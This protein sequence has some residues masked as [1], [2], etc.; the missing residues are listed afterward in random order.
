MRRRLSLP[1]VALLCCVAA[2]GDAPAAAM[3]GASWNRS[4]QGLSNANVEAQA[5]C[6]LEREQA[7]EAAGKLEDA[8]SALEDKERVMR[9][10]VARN[11]ALES[12][13]FA[14]EMKQEE[15]AR[16]LH[17]VT[18]AN[19]TDI[20]AG[21]GDSLRHMGFDFATRLATDALHAERDSAKLM[22][23]TERLL[24]VARSATAAAEKAEKETARAQMST[25]KP[26]IESAEKAAW[27]TWKEANVS[28]A[29]SS[30]EREEIF[31]KPVMKKLAAEVREMFVE[32]FDS[33]MTH[34]Y[35]FDEL[36]P[37][38][39]SGRNVFGADGYALTL[40]DSLDTLAMMGEWERFD[41]A[42]RR[43]AREV[44]FD[45]DVNVSVFETNIR[46]LGG[47]LSAH[48]MA[49]KFLPWYTDELLKMSVDLADRMM[50]AFNTKT[51]IPYGTVNLRHGV[52][53]G[54][55]TVTS[56]AGGGTNVVEFVMLSRIT[57][58]PKY[59][60]AAR[61]ATVGLWS[62][63]SKLGLVGNHINIETG[64]W[65]HQD[66]GLGTN[67]DSFYEY[68][69]KGH[70]LFGDSDF[71]AMFI[72][73]YQGIMK[74]IR[75]GVW[76]LDVNMHSGAVSWMVYSSLASFWPG[77]QV[78]VGDIEPA[79][80]TQYAIHS[81]W[82]RFGGIPEAFNLESG[83]LHNGAEGYPLRPESIESIYYLHKATK[84]PVWVSMGVDALVS[85]QTL[86]KAQCGYA[87]TANVATRRLD[88][89]MDSYFLA[90]TLKYLYLLFD[91]D[92]WLRGEEYV[93]NTEGHPLPVKSEFLQMPHPENGPGS[94]CGMPGKPECTS[95]P[96]IRG[97][98]Q[99]PAFKRMI[100]AYGF[101]LTLEEEEEQV[102]D[103]EED[104]EVIA[105][106]KSQNAVSDGSVKDATESSLS[107]TTSPHDQESLCPKRFYCPE[108]E[109]IINMYSSEEH[110]IDKSGRKTV[111]LPC[112]SGSTSELGS[113]KKSD[114]KCSI[115]FSGPDGG[116][117]NLD[118]VEDSEMNKYLD[119]TLQ[120]YFEGSA[121]PQTPEV[122]ARARAKIAQYVRMSQQQAEARTAAPPD[123]VS[124]SDS[125][126][127]PDRGSPA[128]PREAFNSCTS[129]KAPSYDSTRVVGKQTDMDEKRAAQQWLQDE[130]DE[131]DNELP[132]PGE[133]GSPVTRQDGT[134]VNSDANG[135]SESICERGQGVFVPAP[136][137]QKNVQ[138]QG[139]LMLREGPCGWGW[140]VGDAGAHLSVVAGGQKG[141]LREQCEIMDRQGLYHPDVGG[142][143][144]EGT[145]E[146]GQDHPLRVRSGPCGIGWYMVSDTK[147][148]E[149]A[150]EK[151]DQTRILEGRSRESMRHTLKQFFP[152]TF[153]PIPM[154]EPG[155]RETSGSQEVGESTDQLSGV[156]RETQLA[157]VTERLRH[158]RGI[159]ARKRPSSYLVNPMSALFRKK[160]IATSGDSGD[161]GGESRALWAITQEL[162]D[163]RQKCAVLF[164]PG[165]QRSEACEV[166]LWNELLRQAGAPEI[167]V[168]G[169]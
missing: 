65:T 123:R 153:P 24:E 156:P 10:L 126:S 5:A 43:V 88:D 53:K 117:C 124:E 92:H 110:F 8:K 101:D 3:T 26:S 50:P 7:R 129:S 52:P 21:D 36:R 74:Y 16:Q 163:A 82:R 9:E 145:M 64:A 45:V 133:V 136:P 69:I 59:E 151:Q 72:D 29:K 61:R 115:G 166:K 39:C 165:T 4:E 22:E 19:I 62:R 75:R 91:E 121:V 107:E 27:Q 131:E 35:P 57:K 55:T 135:D 138:N 99:R 32:S 23:M 77:T 95:G 76:Y 2:A 86:N 13:L 113:T 96:A 128:G 85:I 108:D 31:A 37:L 122:Q 17:K 79:V 143:G 154:P 67:V 103:E 158:F 104:G 25:G 54:E 120:G 84:D 44:T 130:D 33:Y 83:K 106:E 6:R 167:F 137:T 140:Y 109:E 63:R 98:C 114:C 18:A 105:V 80:Q 20:K 111:K 141:T 152:E 28:M 78:L 148:G 66:S 132:S 161:S 87:A 93:F 94:G 118:K 14:A 68:L 164:G 73:S 146:Q 89:R 11:R 51:G 34:A 12:M 169:P 56:A 157:E 38:S 127:R 49:L 47:L 102:E 147:L 134:G 150:Q 142:T 116:P 112:P 159:Q 40:I 100:A 149:I 162:E 90:E 30:V 155:A 144:N 71:L 60:R 119:A 1:L 70:L 42:V 15:L 125:D 160:G 97:S 46:A 139:E 41:T 81:L 168:S 48:F 58:D